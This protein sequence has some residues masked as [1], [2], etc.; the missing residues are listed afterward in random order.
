MPRDPF[1]G[2]D[3]GDLAAYYTTCGWLLP[4]WRR[5][6]CVTRHEDRIRTGRGNLEKRFEARRRIG[7][8]AFSGGRAPPPKGLLRLRP[9][10]D[11]SASDYFRIR[12]RAFLSG[13]AAAAAPCLALSSLPVLS[14]GLDVSEL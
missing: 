6:R 13:V 4:L 1:L 3:R 11:S 9:L 12:N 5:R 14:P 2:G 10:C 8:S 7:A